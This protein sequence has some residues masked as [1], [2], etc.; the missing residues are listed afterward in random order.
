MI[1]VNGWI[2]NKIWAKYFKFRWI[3]FSEQDESLPEQ[4]IGSRKV[5]RMHEN[6]LQNT[7]ENKRSQRGRHSSS[8]STVGVYESWI[9]QW[10]VL[11]LIESLRIMQAFKFPWAPALQRIGNIL[12]QRL[13]VVKITMYKGQNI[14][15]TGWILYEDEEAKKLLFF[16]SLALVQIL[17]SYGSYLGMNRKPYKGYLRLKLQLVDIL[18]FT[19]YT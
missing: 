7:S 8:L 19:E 2:A 6:K 12:P 15:N 4:I 16:T 9:F 10:F 13:F 11:V 3:F 17:K 18:S 5:N 1:S 14:Q